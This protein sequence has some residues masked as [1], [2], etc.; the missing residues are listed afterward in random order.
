MGKVI[1]A[2]TL[3]SKRV[4]RAD[5]ILLINPPV[6]ATRYSWIRWNQPL[7]LLKIGTFLRRE[8]GCAVDLIDF[9]KPDRT[10]R[11]S[12]QWLKGV[13][14]HRIVGDEKFPM[15]HFGL[16]YSTLTEW[17][18]ARRA[19]R[20]R[21]PTQIWITSLCSY[22]FTS[23]AQL[24]RVAKDA[25]PDAEIVLLGQYPRLLPS[26]ASETC[27]A[28]LILTQPFSIN[29]ETSAL[30]LYGPALPPFVALQL[31]PKA[32]IT[33][34]KYALERNV[35]DFVF[36][37]DDLFRDGG[38]ALAQV[39]AGARKLASQIRFHAL[40]GLLP[41]RITPGTARLLAGA[42]F[43]ELHLEEA[44]SPSG[45][46]IDTY[47]SA[48]AYLIEAGLAIPTIKLSAFLW[49]GMPGDQVQR[50]VER[51]LHVLSIVGNL[52]LKPFT[53]VPQTREHRGHASYLSQL[54]HQDWSPR[55]FPFA[56]LNK[57]SRADY[58]DLYR[59]TAF[60][61]DKVRGTAFD[62]L[63]GTLGARLLR[64]S[65]RREV[66]TIGDESVSAPN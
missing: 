29:D 52:I 6:E 41:D 45:L 8:V 9:M 31:N 10:G 21:P 16:P 2:R 4:S 48:R 57:I 20:R 39:I 54:P 38:D 46:D 61:N 30:D 50:L 5:R 28:E 37:E 62:F 17:L 12:Q 14:Q 3:I 15:H 59:M 25:L 23:V 51:I 49:I 66:W 42:A 36:F 56:E 65:L 47:T 64:E 55:L 24:C 63:N 60:L 27:A 7:D 43:A 26:H 35:R 33:D 40:C 53:P 32:A 1:S 19:S 22:W 58:H 18:L 11:V 13:N 44:R 34:I